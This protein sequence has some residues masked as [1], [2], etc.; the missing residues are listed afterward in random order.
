MNILFLKINS[1][2]LWI[3]DAWIMIAILL[4]LTYCSTQG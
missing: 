4:V 2:L 3:W 1:K